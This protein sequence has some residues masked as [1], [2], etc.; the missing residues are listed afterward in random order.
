MNLWCCIQEEKFKKKDR[1]G[2]RKNEN[3]FLKEKI[4]KHAK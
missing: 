3:R 1:L 4:E 2:K